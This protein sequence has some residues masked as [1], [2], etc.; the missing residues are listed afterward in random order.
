VTCFVPSE[1]VIVVTSALDAPPA[2]ETDPLAVSGGQAARHAPEQVDVEPVSEANRYSARP[3]LSVRKL[4]RGPFCVF[5]VSDDADD[6]DPMA[7]DE[8]PGDAAVCEL[9]QAVANRPRPRSGRPAQR[10]SAFLTRERA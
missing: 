6:A 1:R 2:A 5:T 9:V 4:P 7:D 3:E 8:P 10:A